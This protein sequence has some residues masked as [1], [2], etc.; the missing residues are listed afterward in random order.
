MLRYIVY[1]NT[2]Q[3]MIWKENVASSIISSVNQFILGFQ[4]GYKTHILNCFDM[5][6]WM[7]PAF[8]RM[9]PQCAG[10]SLLP[11]VLS[12][13]LVDFLLLDSNPSCFLF[14]AFACLQKLIC[15]PSVEQI[16]VGRK[17]ILLS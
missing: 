2:D 4:N 16:S 5:L 6:L 10:N 15:K 14:M 9:R 17:H 12:Y 7:Q 1:L 13:K 3:L 8:L 11:P